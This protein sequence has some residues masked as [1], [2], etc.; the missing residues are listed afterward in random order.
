MTLSACTS[1]ST[2]AR[3]T[4]VF[5]GTQGERRGSSLGRSW[6][7]EAPASELEARGGAAPAS[8]RQALPAPLEVR[9]EAQQAHSATAG[10]AQQ[11]W[12]QQLEVWAI[13][14]MVDATE[15]QHGEAV[16][17][18][19]GSCEE[20][21]EERSAAQEAVRPGESRGCLRGAGV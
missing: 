14:E 9:T 8:S 15:E 3:A 19:P 12:L 1:A 11:Q 17:E 16:A 7:R 13:D 5:T 2:V 20:A 21:A 18:Q 4:R 10:E 6:A